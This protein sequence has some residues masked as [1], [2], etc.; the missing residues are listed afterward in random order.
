MDELQR[1]FLEAKELTEK[2]KTYREWR[3]AGNAWLKMKVG[4]HFY[5]QNEVDY[6]LDM[7]NRVKALDKVLGISHRHDT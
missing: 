4:K 7:A 5:F 6:C 1:L 2:A 3:F